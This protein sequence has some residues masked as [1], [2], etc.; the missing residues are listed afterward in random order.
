MSNNRKLLLLETMKKKTGSGA[1][2]LALRVFN[3]LSPEQTH[4]RDFNYL[5]ETMR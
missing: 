2:M 5:M 3:D 4:S 1:M